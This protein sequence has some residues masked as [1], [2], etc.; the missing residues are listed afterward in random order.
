[1]LPRIPHNTA[2]ARIAVSGFGGLD[3]R[4]G[5]AGGAICAMENLTGRDA[6]VLST[7]PGRRGVASGLTKPR[8]VFGVGAHLY[9]VEAGY[10]YKDGAALDAALPAG[11]DAER[12]FAALGRRL[13]VWPDKLSVDTETDAVSSLAASETRP[14]TFA[15]GTFAGEAAAGNTIVAADPS[16]DWAG[17]F[18]VGDGVTVSGAAAAGNNKTA[19]V[20]E[21]E[22]CRLRFYENTFAVDATAREITV[23]RTVPDLDFLCVNENRV[24]GCKGDTVRCS[25]LGDP[26]N[27]N[28]FDGLSTD[29]WAVETGTSGDFTGCA[30]FLGY[31]VCFKSDRI[32]KVYGSR[33]SNFEV[34]ASATLGVAE[35]AGG[36]LAVAGESLF[37]L[38]RAGFVRYGGGFPS[39]ADAPLATAYAGGAAGSDGRR[40]YVSALRADGARE[41]LVFD[42]QTGAWHREDALAVRG[43]AS[44]GGALYAQTDS[45]V[46]AVGEAASP[47]EADFP[48]S[49]AFADFDGGSFA[50]QYPVRLWLRLECAGAVSVLVSYNGGAF[51]A[52]ASIPAGTKKTACVPVPI[53]RCDR[54]GL[55]LSGA[56]PWKLYALEVET[57][58]QRTRKPG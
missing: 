11:A 19:V 53:R 27:W 44:A 41:V 43:F 38:S 57:R 34:M 42:T 56:K 2:P 10:L 55:R 37:Y 40:Y 49:A 26:A 21:I 23:A 46:L 9:W 24:W 18:S 7:R 32:F 31:P 6:P 54:F 17:V 36:T 14:C 3:R 5:A 29:A 33:P 48:S 8:G 39:A 13:L 35:G 52:A 58:A 16:F 20:R 28:V 30:A 15:D 50:G 12:T 45:A 4:A 1:M 22:G 47:D 25:K 51:E